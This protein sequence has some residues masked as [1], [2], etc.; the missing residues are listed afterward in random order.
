MRQQR[1]LD[2]KKTPK[3]MWFNWFGIRKKRYSDILN[4]WEKWRPCC[5]HLLQIS[6]LPL[7]EPTCGHCSV[8]N[9]WA[10]RVERGP[11][12]R[13]RPSR[14]YQWAIEPA[15]K[16]KNGILVGDQRWFKQMNVNNG[17]ISVWPWASTPCW[18]KKC[19]PSLVC[20][21][22]PP[23]SPAIRVWKM[24]FIFQIQNVNFIWISNT[25]ER[26]M[27]LLPSE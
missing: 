10:Y 14:N 8:S 2:K 9:N 24:N 13:L 26:V 19:V 12:S 1:R 4:E 27:L 17:R 25:C 5:E 6:R 21:N 3:M 22:C 11:D 7:D 23:E 16:Q 18:I 20:V 15:Q